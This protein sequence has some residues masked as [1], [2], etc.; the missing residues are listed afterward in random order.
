VLGMFLLLLLKVINEE[1][2]R[3]LEAVKSSLVALSL[4]SV[5]EYPLH[6]PSS[7]NSRKVGL[8]VIQKYIVE[9]M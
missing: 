6:I 4:K 8:F 3:W 2:H 9:V 1:L 5:S 7:Y